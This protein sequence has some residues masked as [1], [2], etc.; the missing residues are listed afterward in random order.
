[1][2]R[3]LL[4]PSLDYLADLVLDVAQMAN[5]DTSSMIDSHYEIAWGWRERVEGPGPIQ[6][7]WGGSIDR[8]LPS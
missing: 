1:M 3:R 7:R 5:L 8:L 2:E 6:R 4:N